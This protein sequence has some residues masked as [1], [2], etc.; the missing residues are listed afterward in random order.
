[1]NV[2]MLEKVGEADVGD[3][4]SVKSGYAR[5][6]LFPFGKAIPATK[7]NVAIYEKRKEELLKVAKEQLKVS[8]DRADKINGMEVTIE[9]NAS[10]EGKLFGSVGPREIAEAV[11]EAGQ[12]LEKSEVIMPE[13]PKEF[14]GEYD[15]DLDLG[16][17]VSA[18][19]KIVI[20]AAEQS[21]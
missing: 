18:Q 8:Q 16:N 20:K 19:I 10:D 2:I 6:Y 15:I 5:N 13:G 12:E 1:M 17:E 7:E 14:V 9:A 4:V 3:Q 21:A 11:T